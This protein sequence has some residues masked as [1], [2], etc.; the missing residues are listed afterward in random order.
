MLKNDSKVTHKWR[1]Y[2]SFRWIYIS[3]KLLIYDTYMVHIWHI[4]GTYMTHI[5]YIYDTLVFY[6]YHLYTTLILHIY[7]SSISHLCVI[8]CV[9]FVRYLYV[10]LVRLKLKNALCQACWVEQLTKILTVQFIQITISD[11]LL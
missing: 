4:Y 9:S 1:I 11:E 3:K 6:W 7:A 10:V 2:V 5:W 8:L